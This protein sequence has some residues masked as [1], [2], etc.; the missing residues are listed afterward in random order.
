MGSMWSLRCKLQILARSATFSFTYCKNDVAPSLLIFPKSTDYSVSTLSPVLF[1]ETKN[2]LISH[3][4]HTAR[5]TQF[6]FCPLSLHSRCHAGGH[7]LKTPRALNLNTGTSPP[8]RLPDHYTQASQ[9]SISTLHVS[10]S[11]KSINC[12]VSVNQPDPTQSLS[13]HFPFNCTRPLLTTPIHPQNPSSSL[14]SSSLTSKHPCMWYAFFSQNLIFSSF[15][16]II[17]YADAPDTP[18]VIRLFHMRNVDKHRHRGCLRTYGR[19]KKELQGIF[20]RHGHLFLMSLFVLQYTCLDCFRIFALCPV[21][22]LCS[23]GLSD[24]LPQYCF[25]PSPHIFINFLIPGGSAWEI[26][27]TSSM[28]LLDECYLAYFESFVN[29]SVINRGSVFKYSIMIY[30]G[31]FNPHHLKWLQNEQ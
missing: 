28:L 6:L 23:S 29:T 1:D 20:T 25:L 7:K 30:Y 22:L 31:K 21:N 18:V 17:P 4:K 19:F 9:I 24:I 2:C 16:M 13:F 26:H 27:S 12:L 5:H 14:M 8:S 10:N 3:H 15:S 11:F